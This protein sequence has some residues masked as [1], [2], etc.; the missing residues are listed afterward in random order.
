MFIILV[1]VIEIVTYG[2]MSTP[3]IVINEKVVSI[4]KILKTDEKVELLKKNI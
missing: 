1:E 2:L 4:G 3:G